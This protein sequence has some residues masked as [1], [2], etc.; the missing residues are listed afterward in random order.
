MNYVTGG[1]DR[2]AAGKTMAVGHHG[3][4]AEGG[5]TRKHIERGVNSSEAVHL[6]IKYILNNIPFYNYL[7]QVQ[8][9]FCKSTG[10]LCTSYLSICIICAH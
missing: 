5:G 2:S 3:D 8:N 1:S 4:P 6:L 7:S 10:G 9:T